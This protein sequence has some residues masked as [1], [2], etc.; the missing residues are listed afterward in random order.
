MTSLRRSLRAP[1]TFVVGIA[2]AAATVATSPASDQWGT[3]DSDT[4]E[5]AAGT[6][7]LRYR[8]WI[9]AAAV[10]EV[11]DGSLTVS[12]G[13]EP[14]VE[15]SV[16][17]TIADSS[18]T[19]RHDAVRDPETGYAQHTIPWAE[20]VTAC[21]ASG[22]CALEFDITIASSAQYWLTTIALVEGAEGVVDPPAE[23]TLLTWER[24]E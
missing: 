24:I 3:G 1:L 15:A 13:M 14:E 2:I 18:G 16:D 5:S 6:S 4:A 12:A 7:T 9:A 20:L 21:P 19:L 8:L 23:G 10:P 17:L 22:D 11:A